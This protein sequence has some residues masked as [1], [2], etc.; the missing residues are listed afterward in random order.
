MCPFAAPEARRF[1]AVS[2]GNAV[3]AGNE[4]NNSTQMNADLRRE[5]RTISPLLNPT[6]NCGSLL[7]AASGDRTRQLK[8]LLAFRSADPVPTGISALICGW[9]LPVLALLKVQAFDRFDRCL[10]DLETGKP[11]IVCFDDSPWSNAS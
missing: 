11:F 7:S 9:S 4:Q 10:Q 8:N 5:V 2:A 3:I 6:G 1:N